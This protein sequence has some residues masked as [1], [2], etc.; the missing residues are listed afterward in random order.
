[1]SDGAPQ[2]IAVLTVDPSILPVTLGPSAKHVLPMALGGSWYDKGA[3]DADLIAAMET[4]YEAGIRHFD[5]GARY[6]GGHSEELLGNFARGRRET[7]FLASKSD[8]PELT[9][10]AMLT[11]IEGSLKRLRVEAIDLYYI[12]WPRSGRDMRPTMEGME[13]A[14]QQGKIAAVGVSNFSVPQMQQIAEIGRIDAHQLGYNLLWRHPETNIIP[15]CAANGIAVVAYSTLAHGILTGK[16]GRDPGLRPGDQRHTILPF[17]AD[18]WPYVYAGVEELKQ[19]ASKLDLPLATLAL[20]WALARPGVSSVVA[21]AKNREQAVAN[22]AA[23]AAA[24]PSS[25]FERMTAISDRVAGHVPDVGN[26]F[27]HYP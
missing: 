16:F 4:A 12:H 21:G 19:L 5:T 14:R 22:V 11:E 24:I 25:A 3:N 15:Y 2:Q 6:S 17:R 10:A 1:M 13:L 27:N 20:R 26:L 7:M 23:L 9:A 18:I 8:T